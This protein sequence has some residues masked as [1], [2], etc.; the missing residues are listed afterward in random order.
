MENIKLNDIKRFQ[1]TDI[2]GWSVSRFD[3][4]SMCKRQYY[5]DYYGK[6]DMEFGRAKITALKAMTSTAL[7]TGNVIHDVLKAFLERLLRAEAPINGAKFLDYGAKKASEYCAAKIFAEVYY[8]DV[9]SIN[10]ES[11][12][13]NVRLGLSNFLQSERSRWIVEKALS[14]KSGWVIE[15]PGF[16]ETRIDDMK[17]YTKVDFLFPVEGRIYILDWKTGKPDE[18]KH[19]KQL[20][21]YTTWASYHFGKQASD[22]SPI[23]AYLLPVYTEM[24]VKADNLDIEKFKVSVKTE[25]EQM[26]SYLKDIERNIPKAKQEFAKTENTRVCGFCNYREFCFPK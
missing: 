16:G 26:Y 5:Y 15:P 3:K 20:I 6:Y 9:P 18:R 11:I 4:F 1:Y 2:L 23:T 22:I 25:T 12:T 13:A 21:G 17:A 10:I 14:N 19:A 7:E 8:G 24:A